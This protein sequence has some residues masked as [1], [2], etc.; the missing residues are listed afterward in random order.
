[1]GIMPQ[2]KSPGAWLALDMRPF[3]LSQALLAGRFRLKTKARGLSLGDRACL[4]LGRTLGLPVLTTDRDWRGV[5]V[6]VEVV[7]IR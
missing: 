4:A 5:D 7:L 3:D 2:Q 1:M 6:T